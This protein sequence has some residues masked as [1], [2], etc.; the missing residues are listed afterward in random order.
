MDPPLVTSQDKIR[1][2][3]TAID[4]SAIAADTS[5]DNLGFFDSAEHSNQE[6][7]YDISGTLS[8]A[9]VESFDGKHYRNIM[10]GGYTSRFLENR[11]F[12]WL[13]DVDDD[14]VDFQKPLLEELDIDLSDIYYKVCCV[15]FPLPYFR[16][17]LCIV[18]ESPDF[19][20]P[21]F[22][23]STY[24]LLSLYGQ[25]S[26][27]S[28][29]LTIWFIG[30]FLVFFLARA[31]GGE[32]GYGQVL[33]IVGYCLIPLVVVGLI[34][35]VLSRFRL[36]SVVIGCFGVLWSVYSAGTLLCVEELRGKRTLLLYPV[37]LLIIATTMI[38]LLIVMTVIKICLADNQEISECTWITCLL[39]KVCQRINDI[40]SCVFPN[41]TMETNMEISSE[42]M[43][44]TSSIN[45]TIKSFPSSETATKQEPF[46][47]SVKKQVDSK[48][49]EGSFA[50]KMLP[51]ICQ[52]PVVT[53][54]CSKVKL[55]WYYN[56]LRGRCERFSF[57]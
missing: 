35:S 55:L 10:R 14:I 12:G 41:D 15:L 7:D 42:S 54:P 49:S 36:F 16:L 1:N 43:L 56:F 44:S 53:G 30:S 48:I 31:L 57:R 3:H 51:E 34:I 28:W 32:V 4:L 13:L 5:A 26:V 19:W 39:P 17:K 11:G 23:V 46:P 9:N 22:I 8:T 38:L 18:R 47:D 29:I 21:L 2:E 6:G 52:L 45:P 33:G 50:I 37:F 25:L 20:G 40:V 27:L 24:A